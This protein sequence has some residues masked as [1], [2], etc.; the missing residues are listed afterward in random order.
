MQLSESEM[1]QILEVLRS[2]NKRFEHGVSF[3]GC[4]DIWSA[5][6]LL[7][8]LNGVNDDEVF[9]YYTPVQEDL[10]SASG[11]VS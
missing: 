2:L 1:S 6:D 8:T 11:E 7:G 10:N 5:G 4:I 9:W 3:I